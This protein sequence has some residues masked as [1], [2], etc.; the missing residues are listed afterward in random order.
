MGMWI[1][2]KVFK[3]GMAMR[4]CGVNILK[5]PVAWNTGIE[6]QVQCDFPYCLPSRILA[7]DTATIQNCISNIISA[8]CGIILQTY[9]AD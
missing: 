4:R 5:A 7:N 9:I 6:L 1:Q 2:M 3:L 8:V